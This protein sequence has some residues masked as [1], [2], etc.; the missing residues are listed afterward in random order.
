MKANAKRIL[1][2][3]LWTMV[4]V[5]V[6]CVVAM[7]ISNA[8]IVNNAKEKLFSEVDS[9]SPVEYGLLLGTSP[10]TRIGRKSNQFFNYRIDA[11]TQLYKAKKIKRILISG[12]DNSLDGVNEVECMRDS[13]VAHGVNAN[14]IVLDGK[15]YRTLDAV[16]RAVKTYN[17]TDFVV[18]S[19]KFHNER[20]IYLAEHLDLGPCNVTGFNAND[21]TNN[22][23]I[24]TYIREY[25]ARV[26]VFI[27]ILTGKKPA[28]IDDEEING[29]N[30]CDNIDRKDTMGLIAL[31]PQFSRI[32][33]VCGT[34][35]QPDSDVILVAEAAY[36]GK[37]LN[38]F[39][40]SNI[41]GNHVANGVF[42][43]GY[44]CDRNTGAFIYYNDSWTF[45]YQNFSKEMKEAANNG[46]CAF[47]QEMIIYNGKFVEI[48][49]KDNEEHI[50]RALCN[51]DG[52]LCVIESDSKIRFGDFKNKLLSYGVTDA[53]YLDMG[54]GWN[55]AWYRDNRNKI[56][57]LHPKAH[58]YCTNWI[59]F[60]K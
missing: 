59:T 51:H 56:V 17:I 15:G 52:K 8:I 32:D 41:A 16:W 22:T 42:Y 5:G 60:Y 33:L 50:F 21:A 47:G 6:V 48:A 34:M 2:K 26:K 55:H 11:A 10:Q 4:I 20:A 12:S 49:R 29:D 25:F 57:V 46:G 9:V 35:P 37:L 39:N 13:L 24:L 38:E 19:Q 1:K 18:I 36:T 31:Y 53:L 58:D 23:A 3:M 28:S 43:D 45:Y 7:V 40:H 27:D 44:P 30:L 14:D 54:R